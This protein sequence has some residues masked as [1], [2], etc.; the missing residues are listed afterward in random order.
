MVQA[1]PPLCNV[2]ESGQHRSVPEERLIR[3]RF[4]AD[5]TMRDYTPV[6]IKMGLEP[7]TLQAGRMSLAA[8]ST[9]LLTG[10]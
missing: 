10:M 9:Q 4:S 5:T 2:R 1:G 7:R 3:V 8:V 6:G